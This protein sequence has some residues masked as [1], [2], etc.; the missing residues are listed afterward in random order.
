MATVEQQRALALA[1]ARRRRAEAETVTP[2]SLPPSANSS[3]INQGIANVL[4]GPV[5]LAQAGINALITSEG[6]DP[7]PEDFSMLRKVS[8]AIDPVR[9]AHQG[10]GL[11]GSG[12]RA[13]GAEP[14]EGDPFGGSESIKDAF[15]AVNVGVPRRGEQ[16]TNLGARIARGVGEA[17]GAILPFGAISR[18]AGGAKTLGAGIIGAELVSGAGAGAGAHVAEQVAPGDPTAQLIAEIVGGI[19]APT[20]LAA[21]RI[22]GRVIKKGVQESILPFTETGG[23]I[24]AERRVK[25]LVPDADTAAK[26]LDK[27][28]ITKTT[29]ARKIGDERL[30]A[31]EDAV[32]GS[33]VNV[34]ESIKRIKEGGEDTLRK[35]LERI[36]GAGSVTDTKKS[37]AA[38]QERFGKLIDDRVAQATDAVDDKVSNLSPK[39]REAQASTVARQE[40]EGALAD[41]R[42]QEKAL[43]EKVPGDTL[44]E[45]TN[46]VDTFKKL[47]K[48]TPKAQ[49]EDVP[50]S[51]MN[52]VLKVQ[53]QDTVSGLL[54]ATG[55]NIPSSKIRA[56]TEKIS[57]LQGLRS[58]LLE[59]SRVARADGKFNAARINDLLA[60]AILEDMGAATGRVGGEAGQAI[61]DARIFSAK[62]N[63][64]FTQGEIGKVLG[65][66]KQGG[67]KVAPELTLNKL[68]GTGGVKGDIGA[69]KL[70][71]AAD[72]PELRESVEDFLKEKLEKAAIK[73][74]VVNPK[75]ARKFMKEN[76][77]VLNRF[78]ALKKSITELEQSTEKFLSQSKRA[79]AIQSSLVSESKND[80]SKFINAP[81]G[82]E[83]DVIVN[84]R[85]PSK[86][87]K[88]LVNRAAKDPSGAAQQGL[89][90]S[91]VD[92]VIGKSLKDGDIDGKALLNLVNKDKRVNQILAAVLSPKELRRVRQIGSELKAFQAIST[93]PVGSLLDDLPANLL[94][95]PIRILALR[96]G[97]KFG[98]GT[99]GASLFTANMFSQKAKKYIEVFTNDKARQLITQAVQDEDLMKT[100]LMNTTS[101]PARAKAARR[102][103]AWLL[104][105]GIRLLEE[106]PQ[107]SE[108]GK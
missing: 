13:L 93:K 87:A 59:K 14:L 34:D 29:P 65:S 6:P 5:D 80:V 53:Q 21:S 3:F 23:R 25:A 98:K 41:T 85:N 11:V 46:T 50:S 49:L 31:L 40:L 91:A 76:N 104:G 7:I 47:V 73:D 38:R 92:F 81:I 32:R 72:S 42:I 77:D 57:E 37:L 17:G 55:K 79:K 24:R 35:E 20:T 88:D 1:Q 54:D 107:E 97:A 108:E 61:N 8:E 39:M 106:D 26:A 36:K 43:W 71:E 10:V 44:I 70:I 94:E 22:P 52:K 33:D 51:L 82:K 62:L 60:D 18:A 103:E 75:A 86:F 96:T 28:T 19:A 105:P 83:F 2:P 56:T 15:R 101:K 66:A 100:L 16:P 68:I 78:P 4:G 12:L 95:T 58:K 84:S 48:D 64:K 27:P 9:V 67:A 69:K 45:K 63:E 30:I 99:S 74:G 102:L 89:K 90:A